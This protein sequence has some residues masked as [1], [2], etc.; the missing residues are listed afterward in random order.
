[1]G[2][3]K[4][5]KASKIADKHSRKDHKTAKRSKKEESSDSSSND[6]SSDSSFPSTHRVTH[7]RKK[8]EPITKPSKSS[9]K[10][11]KEK[12]SDS[13]SDL[14]SSEL[15]SSPSK[16][17]TPV[18]ENQSTPA[19]QSPSPTDKPLTLFIG[20]VSY[21]STI[22]SL[23]RAF[24]LYGCNAARILTDKQTG[25]S[26]GCGYLEFKTLEGANR[27]FEEMN[28]TLVDGRRIRLDVSNGR[29][30]PNQPDTSETTSLHI[31]NLANRTD[32][33]TLLREFLPYRP[34][35]VEI[36]VDPKSGKSKGF[37]YVKFRT[38]EQAEQAMFEMTDY[39]LDGSSIKIEILHPRQP[40]QGKF[41]PRGGRGNFT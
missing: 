22:E 39:E 21:S 20:N 13:S 6:S 5:P 16:A 33:I 19:E 2:K 40:H 8:R 30:S 10:S 38:R 41:T 9:K 4:I 25:K 15:S 14:S 31:T 7:R 32:V 24:S 27:A 1:M 36:V 35:N 34:I 18:V 28:N 26:K 17:T 29:P 37:G 11:K 12:T 23:I 3:G